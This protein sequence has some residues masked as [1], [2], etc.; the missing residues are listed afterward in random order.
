MI[1]A[2]VRLWGTTVGTVYLPTGETF[3][4]FEYDKNFIERGVEISPVN[5]PLSR[6][7]YTFTALPFNTFQGL[8]GLLA[9]SLPDKFGNAVINAWL[10][11]HGR[12]PDSMNAV[13]KLC[14]IG[15]RGM[16][17]LEFY[18]VLSESLNE[19]EIV[20]VAELTKLAGD[21][22]AKRESLHL[23]KDDSLVSNLIRVGTSA[24]GARGKAIIAWNEETNEVRSGQTDAGEGFG[25]WIIKFGDIAENRDKEQADRHN[26]TLIEYAYYLMARAAGI[27]MSECR[28]F[29]SDG[30]KHFLTRRFDRIGN[31]GE[32]L[33]MQSLGALGHFDYNSPGAYGYEQAA[34]IMQRLG[35]GQADMEQL[36]RRM[37]FNVF[38]RNQDDH[39]KNISFLM[40]KKGEWS[41]S[42]AYDVTYAYNPGGKWTGSH[43]M[44]INGK[45]DGFSD[46]DFKNCGA[47]MNIRNKRCDE[48]IGEVRE[49]VKRWPEFAGEAG[50]EPEESES[51]S[52]VLLV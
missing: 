47:K 52:K 40:N 4:K 24:G 26:Y 8:P 35:L 29:E 48:I 1:T 13:E 16:G 19:S 43:Q 22:L 12:E 46:E 33:H 18:P 14:Y 49:T 41:L 20:N 5:M 10:V 6:N 51:I 50:L 45:R 32:K 44:T 2:E 17:A 37:V 31:R 3:A 11:S 9:D 7:I 27:K 39:V 34:G 28:L 42:P 23:H 38:A 15:K 36:F 30:T 25:Y 21:I